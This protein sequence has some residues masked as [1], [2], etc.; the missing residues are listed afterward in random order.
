MKRCIIIYSMLVFSGSVW[1]EC[2]AQFN[3]EIGFYQYPVQTIYNGYPAIKFL[4]ISGDT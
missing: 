1:S 3:Y 2:R 4:S